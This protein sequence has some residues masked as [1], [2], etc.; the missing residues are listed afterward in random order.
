MTE[1][2]PLIE[3]AKKQ[4]ID[5]TKQRDIR[6]IPVIRDILS[7]IGQADELLIDLAK[8]N[9]EEIN[10]HFNNFVQVHILPLIMNRDIRITD[11][12]HIF[13]V[14]LLVIDLIKNKVVTTVDLREEQ[15]TEYVWNVKDVDDITVDMIQNIL[16]VRDQ[17]N[18][19][20][21]STSIAEGEVQA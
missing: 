20:V 12:S 8:F 10:E 11:I 2:N 19:P 16:V 7:R 5:Y 18:K 13:K 4:A 21:D 6:V 14:I 3:E 1:T 9:Q 15:A 17:N